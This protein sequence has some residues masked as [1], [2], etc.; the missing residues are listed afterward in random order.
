MKSPWKFLA[1]LTSRGRAA[2]TPAAPIENDAETT[3]IES[4]AQ[5]VPALPLNS[6]KA[7]DRPDH[8]ETPA[9]ALDA[10]PAVALPGDVEEVQVPL[11]DEVSQP[12][13][14][15]P[16]LLPQ[17]ERSKQSPR[18]SQPK[19]SARTKRTRVD[20]ASTKSANPTNKAQTARSPSPRE[21]LLDE[22]VSLDEEITLLR[23]QLARKLD[24]QNAQLKK[25]LQRF[26]VS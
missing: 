2:Q 3:A 1:Q 4:G 12:S 26:D 16:A 18:A 25:L 6:A 21:T 20:V 11:R 22:A 17:N 8:D 14:P 23:R 9:V 24:L 5:Q 19:R 10:T 13:A 7:S 15:A